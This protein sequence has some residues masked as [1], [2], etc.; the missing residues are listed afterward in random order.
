MPDKGLMRFFHHTIAEY[1]CSK[2]CGYR[3][4]IPGANF[5][6]F[7]RLAAV[8]AA[9]PLWVVSLFEPW[10][11][12]WYYLISILAGELLLVYFAGFISSFVMIP[13]TGRG[14]NICPQCRAP[15]LLAGRHFDP[16]GSAKPLWS[17]FV[18]FAVFIALNVMLWIGLATGRLWQ[19]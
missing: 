2:R 15:V 6:W 14:T 3:R 18:I 5:S 8:L 16:L 9:L 4:S 12:P 10:H 17:D 7:H 19:N 1:I 13:F 11:F